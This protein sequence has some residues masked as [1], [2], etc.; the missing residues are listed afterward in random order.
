MRLAAFPLGRVF[1]LLVFLT[2]QFEASA[3]GAASTSPRELLAQGRADE[4]V[5]VLDQQIAHSPA[6]ESYNLLCRAHFM[7]EE[8][9]R[10]IPDCERARDLDPKNSL[11]DLWLGRI[12]GEKAARA[13]F[14]SAAGLVKK[15]R[16]AF[17]RAVELDP[18]NWQARTDLA[19][20]Y[21]DAPGI[22][23]GGKDKARE[24]ADALMT[25]NPAR[26][27]WVAGR[28]AE[29]NKDAAAAELEYRGAVAVSHSAVREWVDLANFY[30]HANRLDDMEQALRH[31]ESAPVDLA[32]SLMDGAGLLFHTNRDPALA[33]RLLR[34]YLAA[35]VEEGP[36]F[37]AHD[38]L[39]HFLEKQ[40][41]RDGAAQE[42]RAALSLAHNYARAQE[43]LKRLSH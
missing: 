38:L 33:I 12:Y 30:R 27:H 37:K 10:G 20:F 2:L 14:M 3:A 26:S 31:L 42:Y 18:S 40:G 15:V 22:V 19:E 5:E 13:G 36:A 6:A 24:Q 21:I 43:D 41:D 25:L 7:L 35:P 17:E 11:Y 23:G 9:D 29:K 34:R 39:G 28:I 8:W 4:A 1:F 32:D 16:V